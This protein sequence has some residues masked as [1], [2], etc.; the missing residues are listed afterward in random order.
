MTNCYQKIKLLRELEQT[1]GIGFFSNE[2]ENFANLDEDSYNMVR[3]VFGLRRANP[4]DP[5][6]AGKLYGAVVNKVTFHNMVRAGKGGL[7]C[8]EEAIKTHIELITTK[9]SK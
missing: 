2:I 8:D 3:L 4:A 9:N 1:W 6:E 5:I 7:T